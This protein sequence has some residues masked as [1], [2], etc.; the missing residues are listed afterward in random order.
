MGFCTRT[1]VNLA[2]V[3]AALVLLLLCC[4]PANAQR[5]PSPPAPVAPAPLLTPTPAPAPAPAPEFA[6]L[7]YLLSYAGP[8]H[9]FLG[10]LQSTKVLDTFQNQANNTVQGLTLFV[11]SDK[12]F[13]SLKNPS[14]ANLTQDQRRSLCLFHALPHYYPLS[15]FGTLS[16]QSPIQTFAG[17]SYSLNFT[18]NSGDIRLDSGWTHTK[19]I[20]AVHAADPVA[21]YETDKV[22]LP[23][24]IFGTDIPPPPP[25]APA[26]APTAS[27]PAADA[28]EGTNRGRSSSPSASAAERSLVGQFRYIMVAAAMVWWYL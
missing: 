13:S 4:A 18:D 6:N 5:A 20:S 17:A 10:M 22:L 21:L 26:P 3:S 25:P 7:T 9:I 24:S 16:Q 27:P 14:L 11:P 12:A 15:E 2:V 8:F 28:P 23:M 19:I 1:S